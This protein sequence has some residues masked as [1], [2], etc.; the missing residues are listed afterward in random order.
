MYKHPTTEL[1]FS[2][3]EIQPLYTA[4]PNVATPLAAQRQSARSAWVGLTQPEIV[5]G[6]CSNPH[7]VQY[8]SVFEK[9]ARWAEAKL[10][11]KNT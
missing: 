10:K 9:G 6:F 8:V 5:E 7:E 1:Q 11:E 2:N 3:M 4:S